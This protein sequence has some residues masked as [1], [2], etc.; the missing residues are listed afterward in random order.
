[1]KKAAP[2][3][4]TINK[5][6]NK[7]NQRLRYHSSLEGYGDFEAMQES[8]NK[9]KEP[10]QKIKKNNTMYSLITAL[11]GLI[12]ISWFYV[13]LQISCKLLKTNNALSTNKIVELEQ[14]QIELSHLILDR[15]TLLKEIHHR[16]KNNLQ[17]IMSLFNLQARKMEN[18]EIKIFLQKSQSRVNTMALIHESLYQ[19]C[20]F[21]TVNFQEYLE[22]LTG[23]IKQIYEQNT[24]KLDCFI[25]A[26]DFFFD[27]QTATTLGLIASE[28]L[29]NIIKHAFPN[30]SFKAAIKIELLRFNQDIIQL[31]ISDN[32]IGFNNKIEPKKSFGLELVVLLVKQID[33]HF[34]IENENGTK[35]II[36]FKYANS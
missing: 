32:G 15:D 3:S 14:I 28:L 18:E 34:K 22:K 36:T 24:I 4:S 9:N 6:G 35:C 20:N 8:T 30:E 5:F 1:M 12:L 16:I 33:G 19:S 7:I 21:E 25:A 10:I 2:K 31:F 26:K 23:S 17:L 27:I 11:S 13:K 29:S